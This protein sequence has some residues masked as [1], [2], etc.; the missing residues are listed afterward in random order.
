MKAEKIETVTSRNVLHQEIIELTH[1]LNNSSSSI[2]L[3][4]TKR[5]SQPNLLMESGVLW[6]IHTSCHHQIIYAKFN[7]D[8]AY[9]LPYERKFWH[10]QKANIDL[11]KRSINEYDSEKAFIS[12]GFHYKHSLVNI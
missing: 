9:P 12:T 8:I 10:Y 3:I 1:I 5:K 6:F 7:L 2:D 11:I 4:T